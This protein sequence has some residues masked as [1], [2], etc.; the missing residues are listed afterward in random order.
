[1]GDEIKVRVKEEKVFINIY[2]CPVCGKESQL[3]NDIIKCLNSHQTHKYN[4]GDAIRFYW[5]PADY[6]EFKNGIITQTKI[7]HSGKPCYICNNHLIDIDEN[8]IIIVL[9][10]HKDRCEQHHYLMNIVDS[11]QHIEGI[12]WLIEWN[13][14]EARYQIIGIKS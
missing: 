6:K 8:E 10:S 11:I 14:D 2:T 13:D 9:M 12:V 1:M 3:K 5:Y 7:N 4:I